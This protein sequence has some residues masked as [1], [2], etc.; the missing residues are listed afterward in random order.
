MFGRK[1]KSSNDKFLIAASR[2]KMGSRPTANPP[3][4]KKTSRAVQSN[5][6]PA[7]PRQH[8][9]KIGTPKKNLK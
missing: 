3:M 5:L 7:S 4:A 8:L 2:D 9:G 6:H 1:T